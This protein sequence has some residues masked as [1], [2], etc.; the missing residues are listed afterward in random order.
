[1]L[2]LRANTYELTNS[3]LDAE[4][5]PAVHWRSD[6][7]VVDPLRTECEELYFA[8]VSTNRKKN[9][10]AG[11]RDWLLPLASPIT[12]LLLA[13]L[14]FFSGI[15]KTVLIA[16]I[17]DRIAAKAPPTIEAGITPS[18]KLDEISKKLD[19]IN[20]RLHS[21]EGWKD[22]LGSQVRILKQNVEEQKKRIAQQEAI[23]RFQ[24][25]S[26]VLAE[27]QREVLTALES[28]TIVPPGQLADYKYA[29]LGLPESANGYWQIVHMVITLESRVRQLQGAA[30]DPRKVARPCGGVTQNDGN[31]SIRN[32]YVGT[33]FVACIVDLDNQVFKSVIFKDC[34]VRYSGGTVSL[35][36]AR[37]INCFFVFISRAPSQPVKPAE[38]KLL[39]GI[40]TAPTQ[41]NVTVTATS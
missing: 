13:A 29:I 39:L 24:D 31:L 19:D 4:P 10:F 28:S 1:M 33:P 32:A 36:G 12:V 40:L 23:N 18:P 34:V 20:G 38:R 35:Q 15:W 27:I 25:P 9:W 37:F 26:R 11:N 6:M 14:A 22:G 21:I 7:L 30:P 2:L 8:E 17:D 16:A 5:L 41:S 3:K